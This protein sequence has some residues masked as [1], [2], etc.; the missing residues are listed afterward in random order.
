MATY[1]IAYD[2][3]LTAIINIEADD[4]Y[5]AIDIAD[6][7]IKTSYKDEVLR[8]YVSELDQDPYIETEYVGDGTT[9]TLTPEEINEY[10]KEVK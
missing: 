4:E 1:A 10:L 9:P 5:D 7:L 6:A 8:E 2:I 3:N